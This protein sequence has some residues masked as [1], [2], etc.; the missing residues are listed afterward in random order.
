[1]M[2]TPTG[3]SRLYIDFDGYFAAVEEQASARLH[4]RP[5]GVIPFANARNSCVISANARAKR[6]GVGTGTRI[7]ETRRRCPEIALVPQRP[8]VYV[9]THRRIVAAVNSVMP[10]DA[11]CSIDELSC[12][13]GS[14]DRPEEVGR[15]IKTRGREAAGERV[16]CSMGIAPNRWLAK[17]AADMRK[18]D[19]F[20]VLA[21]D[22]RHRTARRRP[23]WEST[24]LQ[25][26]G[27]QRHPHTVVP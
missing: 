2:R 5:V 14:S 19:G 16:T 8:D 27:V 10:I 21:P 15:R 26:L 4:G 12:V 13:L 25:A 3:T 20:T 17:V 1:M 7:D 9:R 22:D 6:R 24:P 11:V 23:P 18:P